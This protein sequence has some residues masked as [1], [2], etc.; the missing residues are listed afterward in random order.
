V[1]ALYLEGLRFSMKETA[2]GVEGFMK[3]YHYGSTSREIT[4]QATRLNMFGSID[5]SL[6]ELFF[7]KKMSQ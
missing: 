5:K 4:V 2:F 7:K 3:S 1:K 6:S